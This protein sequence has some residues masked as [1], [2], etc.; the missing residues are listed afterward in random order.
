L[1]NKI[2]SFVSKH[3][4]EQLGNLKPIGVII[5]FK[6]KDGSYVSLYRD[7]EEN[8]TSWIQGKIKIEDKI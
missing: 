8:K 7:E 2:M 3:I 6:K 4:L 5:V 1:V